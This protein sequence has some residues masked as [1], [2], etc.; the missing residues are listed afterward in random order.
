MYKDGNQEYLNISSTGLNIK[1]ASKQNGGVTEL[2][3]IEWGGKNVETYVQKRRSYVVGYVEPNTFFA[4]MNT[5]REKELGQ[6]IKILLMDLSTQFTG[7]SELLIMGDVTSN[8]KTTCYSTLFS[9]SLI[10]DMDRTRRFA[11]LAI[12]QIW[13]RPDVLFD[14]LRTL[15]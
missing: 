5:L 13:C 12:D 15:I 7:R 10:E 6:G 4:I 1:I 9:K 2:K 14:T 11:V 3:N 8:G